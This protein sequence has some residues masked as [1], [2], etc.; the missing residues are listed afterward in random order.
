MPYGHIRRAP[1]G[2]LAPRVLPPRTD[3]T[4]MTGTA[5]GQK[6]LAQS[7]KTAQLGLEAVTQEV[8]APGS[9]VEEKLAD[10]AVSL[11]GAKVANILPK[12]KMDTAFEADL[13][14]ATGTLAV[15]KVA[16]GY[17]AA[18][19][20]GTV[21]LA[22]QVSGTLPVAAVATGYPVADL[23]VGTLPA[24]VSVPGDRVSG[25]DATSLVS[26]LRRNLA[27]Q[28]QITSEPTVADGGVIAFGGSGV[29]G[30]KLLDTLGEMT[31]E[32]GSYDTFTPADTAVVSIRCRVQLR[33]GTT[34][35][36]TGHQAQLTLMDQTSGSPVAA[37]EWVPARAIP[38][39]TIEIVVEIARQVQ[40]A[41]GRDHQ[42]L[43]SVVN[44]SGVGIPGSVTIKGWN[45]GSGLM[46]SYF[47]VTGVPQA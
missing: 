11:S 33:S 12:E 4:H 31:R 1:R 23:G 21:D 9:V 45:A 43:L 18:D 35:L 26:K 3:V 17:P 25:L 15:A 8:L 37:S 38:G 44:S 41:K 16:T 30:S 32:A 10:G 20:G 13:A 47:E 29:D 34:T 7:V 28:V 5:D 42:V 22:S 40:V 24:A 39:G 14:V 19:L 6:L 46:G 2:K 36:T 27:V